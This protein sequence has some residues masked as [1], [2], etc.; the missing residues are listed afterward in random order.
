M[1]DRARPPLPT[2]PIAIGVASGDPNFEFGH[3]VGLDA[4]DDGRVVVLDRQGARIRVFDSDGALLH[5]FGGTGE[6]PGEFS[7]AAA[8]V[9]VDG[10]GN[11]VVPDLGNGRISRSTAEGE[12]IDATTLQLNPAIGVPLLWTTDPDRRLIQQ[13]RRMTLPGQPAATAEPADL[14]LAMGPDG[15]VADTLAVL[16]VGETFGTGGEAMTIRLFAPETVWALLPGGRFVTGL[17]SEYSLAVRNPNGEVERIIRRAFDQRAVTAGEEEGLR[18]AL[19]EAWRSA[20]MPDQAISQMT[21][22]VQFAEEWPV[23]AS[24]LGADDA[25]LWVQRVDPGEEFEFP[26]FA[27]LQNLQVGSGTWDVF[28]TEGRLLGTVEIPR[29]VTPRRILGDFIYGV[30][31]DELGVQQVVRFRIER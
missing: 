19:A 7:L 15:V 28:D 21:G 11:L 2:D 23:L 13:V 5:A 29:N 8:G 20:G 22:M 26:T 12:L 17:N 14:L 25:T 18:E 16:P 1:R 3:I 6:G 10:E 4:Y 24:V 30:R 31:Q 9:F 27:D